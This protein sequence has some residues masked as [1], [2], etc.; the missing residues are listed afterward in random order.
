MDM[1]GGV[2]PKSPATT[3]FLNTGGVPWE[4]PPFDQDPSRP[5]RF[6]TKRGCSQGDP[7]SPSHWAAFFDILL[8]ALELGSPEA[9]VL[10]GHHG[11]PQ[12]LSDGAFV[13]DL[14]TVSPTYM[15]LQHKLDIV[16]AFAIVF[17]LSVNIPKLKL[18]RTPGVADHHPPHMTIHT[19]GW[20]PRPH[21]TLHEG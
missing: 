1:K 15:S 20:Q 21:H 6:S 5:G 7:P 14:T 3:E 10:P 4:A 11:C 16:C 12:S 8:R 2:L 9:T 18:F 17:S 13:D 19:A